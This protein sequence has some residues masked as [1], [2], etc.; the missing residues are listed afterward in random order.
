MARV[1]ALM[2]SAGLVAS[3]RPSDVLTVPPPSGVTGS[4]ALQN[5]AGAEGLLTQGRAQ[6]FQGL[7]E[8][9]SGTGTG[10][11]QWSNLLADE[12][13]W[14]FFSFAAGDANIDARITVGGAGYV[15]AGDQA[16]Q[17]L[18]KAR[19]TLLS[20]IPSLEQYEPAGG[21]SKIGEAFALVGYT[22]LLAAED[23]C[24]GVTLDALGSA[25]GVTY[26]TPLSTDSLLA[27]AEADF[28]SAVAY[29]GT[30]PAIAPLAAVGLARARLNRGHYAD[31][32]TAVAAVPTSFVYNTEL[33]PGG[34]GA[35]QTFNLY[36]QE[37]S[38]YGCGYENVADRKGSNGINY[39]SAQDPRLVLSTTAAKTCDG[40][41]AGYADSIWYYPVKFGTPSTFIPLASGVEA[42]LMEAEAALRANQAGAW[43]TDLTNLRADAANT[44]VTFDTSQ[45]PIKSDSTTAASAAAQVDFMFRE[46]AFWLFG[47]GTR[48]GDLRRLIRHYG[49]D[50]STVFPIGPYPNAANAHLPSPLPNFGTDVN[51]TLPTPTGGLSTPNPNYKGCIT[52]TKTA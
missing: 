3:C 52:S 22:E 20:A 46:R 5:Q 38:G 14:D 44:H 48:L 8:S 32:A 11:L 7:A 51:L 49:R 43:A 12:F 47:T 28:D 13:T 24:A 33:Q 31:A 50:Q 34:I 40:L 4:S 19:L 30:D 26:G 6:A 18:L 25:R 1:C 42:R 39:R 35:P 45:V 16:I 17:L 29:A 21:R 41:F 2:G 27:V 37:L 15:E 36:A 10:L 9:F 23:Y